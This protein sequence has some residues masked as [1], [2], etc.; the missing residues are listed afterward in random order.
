MKH[1]NNIF[2]WIAYNQQCTLNPVLFRCTIHSSWVL[3]IYAKNE[4]DTKTFVYVKKYEKHFKNISLLSK[5]LHSHWTLNIA[6]KKGNMIYYYTYGWV[7]KYI[8]TVTVKWKL[9]KRCN[10]VSSLCFYFVCGSK[11]K[12]YV[13][14]NLPK[15]S[16]MHLFKDYYQMFCFSFLKNVHFLHL[17]LLKAIVIAEICF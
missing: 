9:H 15:N 5:S 8:F 11:I 3:K 4:N 14:N 17:V 6:P 2:N 16:R 13:K 12:Y 7:Q 10:I 1:K